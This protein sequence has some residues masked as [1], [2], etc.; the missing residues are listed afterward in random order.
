[1][2]RPKWIPSMFVVLCL[3]AACQTSPTPLAP[4]AAV[5]TQPPTALPATPSAPPAATAAPAASPTT[6]ASATT[7][8]TAI[9]STATPAAEA[10]IYIGGPHG[11][12][13]D[14]SG[15]LYY[16]SC[17][18][19]PS[20]AD[21]EF[22]IFTLDGTGLVK[23]YAG[24]GGPGGGGDNGPAL[25]ANFWCPSGVAFGPDGSLYVTDRGNARVR[26]IDKQG[27]ITTVAGSGPLGDFANFNAA[28]GGFSG[29]GG[30]ATAAELASPTDVAVDQQGNLYIADH[31]NNRVR[32]VDTQGMITTVA[33]T[34]TAGFSG[35]GGPATKAQ[36]NTETP[37]LGSPPGADEWSGLA[38]DAAGNLYIADSGNARIRK[39]DRKGVITT[40]AGTGV[41]GFSGDSGPA[42]A[43]ELSAPTALALDAAGNLYIADG[44]SASAALDLKY[45]D[46]NYIRK[47]DTKGIITTLA[48]TG[49]AGYSGDGGPAVKASLSGPSSI[50]VDA[51]GTLY[52]ADAGNNHL[53]KIDKAG[54]ITTV[55]GVG[56]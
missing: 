22:Q 17:Y 4:T 6:A 16:S 7:A 33:G 56:S 44:P 36:L 2:L 34:G 21:S 10:K 27:V 18:G 9:P 28:P 5:A 30:P 3:L 20:M 39:V 45:N 52:I 15:T 49:P 47:V 35:D 23:V 40:I 55:A 42:K 29:D 13:L 41:A 48:G 53:R 19:G 46:L 11:L 43:A 32:K 26:R 51:Q 1:M 54:V 14:A 25:Q 31:N 37:L 12:T 24:R 50:I 8:P 38:V